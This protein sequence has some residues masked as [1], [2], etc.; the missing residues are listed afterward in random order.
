M[1]PT[2][3]EILDWVKNNKRITCNNCHKNE[4]SLSNK[5][6]VLFQAAFDSSFTL[7]EMPRQFQR[8][9]VVICKNCGLTQF[10]DAKIAGFLHSDS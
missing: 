7:N 4:F 2:E 5:Y 6:G 9:I 3:P 1:L 10:F 8:L